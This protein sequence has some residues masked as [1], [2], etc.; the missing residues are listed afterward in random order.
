MGFPSNWFEELT[1]QY[2]KNPTTPSQVK[3]QEESEQGIWQEE[4]F[5]PAQAAILRRVLFLDS[6]TGGKEITR[7]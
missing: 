3:P 6:I 4:A 2:S 1:E 7:T 5:T